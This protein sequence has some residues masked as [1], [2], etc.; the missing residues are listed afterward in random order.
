MHE[1]VDIAVPVG[2]RRTFAYSVPLEMREQIA[3]GMRVLVPFG[4]K[5][6]TGYVVGF[7]AALSGKIKLRPVRELLEPEPAIPEALV[8][9]ALW[10][11]RYYFAP[12]GEVFRALFPTG[13]QV[14]GE[15]RV[16]LT[17]RTAALLQGG[18][19][20]MGLRPAEDTILDILSS[21]PSLTIKQLT[22]RTKLSRAGVLIES[23]VS[24]QHLKVETR[25]ETP[26]VKIKEQLEIRRLAA[27]GDAAADLP[28]AQKRL[29]T[30]LNPEGEAVLLQE[31]LQLSK[32]TGGVARAL[33]QKGLV[34]IAA[35]QLQRMPPEL[36]PAPASRL[37]PHGVP[38]R[39]YRPDF[40]NDP[41]ATGGS[42]FDSRCDR[43]R[44]DGNLFASDCGSVAHGRHRD[45]SCPGNRS[46]AAAQPAGCIPFSR[47]RVAVAQRHVGGRAV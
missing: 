10:V 32:S 28:A 39:I 35:T 18:F 19:R 27:S 4:R 44:Q 42:L 33:E 12:P 31:A 45:V 26:K 21:E 34:E 23:L 16:S 46:H 7:P 11:A 2:V 41:A 37:D 17:P 8:E 20:P 13:T 22:D 15:R 40:G 25:I 6:V 14:S 38:K 29:Y 36:A 30:I 9:T 3:A 47:P 1:I 43:K 5:L 24:A